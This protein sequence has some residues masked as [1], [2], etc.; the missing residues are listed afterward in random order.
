MPAHASLSSHPVVSIQEEQPQKENHPPAEEEREKKD[1]EEQPAQS[2]PLG[3]LTSRM[4]SLLKRKNP[5][6]KKEK[7][8]RN[9]YELDRVETVHWTEL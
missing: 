6:E 7:R 9:Y 1:E 5:G 8:K 4:K 2:D 3:K